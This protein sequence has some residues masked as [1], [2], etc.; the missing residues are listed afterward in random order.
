MTLNLK[1]KQSVDLAASIDETDSRRLDLA[2]GSV[3]LSAKGNSIYHDLQEITQAALT[4]GD[5]QHGSTTYR[6]HAWEV[7][8]ETQFSAPWERGDGGVTSGLREAMNTD[9]LF[10]AAPQ[11]MVPTPGS[12]NGP[13]AP[14]TSKTVL[15]VKV[16]KQGSMPGT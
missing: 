8:S 15:T 16:Q 4:V 12:A 13:P 7:L 9:V 10:I 14:G 11:D 5:F 6:V 1:D 3:R 2:H